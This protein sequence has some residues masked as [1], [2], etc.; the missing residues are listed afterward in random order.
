MLE[1]QELMTIAEASKW[2]TDYLKKN[3]TTSNI[4]YL[5]QYGRIKK[6]ATNGVSKISKKELIDYYISF[7]GKRESD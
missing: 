2:A 6:Y 5:V 7:L 3:V 4:S 1:T